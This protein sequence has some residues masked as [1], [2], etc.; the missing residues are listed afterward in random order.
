MYIYALKF[1][2]VAVS[3]LDLWPK[4]VELSEN[5]LAGVGQKAKSA[6]FL[7]AKYTMVSI[8]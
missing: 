3:K 5:N 4:C 7:F 2:L 6:L 1:L 8:I